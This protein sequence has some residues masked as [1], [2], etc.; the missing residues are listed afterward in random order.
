MFV[1]AL[2][3]AQDDNTKRKFYTIF[4]EA[5]LITSRYEKNS[6]KLSHKPRWLY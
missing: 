5:R 6:F 1:V 2:R 4:K 3:Q